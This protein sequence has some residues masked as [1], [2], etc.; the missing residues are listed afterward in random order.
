MSDNTKCNFCTLKSIE[1]RTAKANQVSTLYNRDSGGMDVYVHPKKIKISWE[2]RK[3]IKK[4]HVCWF[5][6]LTNHCVC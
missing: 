5:M 4:Y 1:R 2:N 3:D 6:E